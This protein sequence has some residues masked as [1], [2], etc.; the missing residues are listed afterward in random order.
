M[1]MALESIIAPMPNEIVIPPAM[2]PKNYM[3][4]GAFFIGQTGK[5]DC[6]RRCPPLFH[7]LIRL[8]RQ[9]T[10]VSGCGAIRIPGTPGLSQMPSL[11]E[12]MP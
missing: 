3:Q 12:Q 10:G 5:T 11:F 9:M 4:G 2:Y 8:L 1:L 6:P 7:C